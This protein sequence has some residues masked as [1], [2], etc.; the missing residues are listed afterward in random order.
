LLRKPWNPYI[1]RHTALTEKSLNPKIAHIL[2]QHAG[3]VQGSAMAQKYLHY[4][5][6]ASSES[7]LEAF[8][9]VP[10]EKKQANTLKPKI[11]PNCFESNKPDSKFGA[12]C[13]MVLTYDAYNEALESEKQKEDKLSALEKQM[14][15]LIS[16]LGN[17]DQS[18]KNTFTKQLFNSGMYE[19]DINS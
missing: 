15:S 12:S 4:F 14:Q 18:T 11:C 13:R 5:S 6:N 1:R 9:I 17:M 16:A 19:K 7:I 3:W 8:G 2:N 10:T